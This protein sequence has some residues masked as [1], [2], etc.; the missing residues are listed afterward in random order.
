MSSNQIGKLLRAAPYFPVSD[1]GRSVAFYEQTLGFRCE[2]AP[3]F[4]SASL[5]ARRP[6]P[7]G[8]GLGALIR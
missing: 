6:R 1:V 8:A 2:W 4:V 5:V 7:C 3:I